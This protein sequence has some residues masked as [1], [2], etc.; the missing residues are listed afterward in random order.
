MALY[1]QLNLGGAAIAGT[2]MGVFKT[3]LSPNQAVETPW[4]ELT[5]DMQAGSWEK[6]VA[7]RGAMTKS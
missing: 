5:A 2:L 6:T 7:P 1:K 4:L 3:S